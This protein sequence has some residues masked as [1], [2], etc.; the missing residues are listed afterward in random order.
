MSDATPSFSVLLVDLSGSRKKDDQL[1]SYLEEKG[2]QVKTV[3]NPKRAEDRIRDGAAQLVFLLLGRRKGN[4]PSAVLERFH[5][6]NADVPTVVVSPRPSLDQVLTAMRGRAFDFLSS[7]CRWEDI[8]DCVQT[9]IKEKGYSLTLEDRLNTSLGERLRQARNER[10]LTLRQLSSRTGLSVSLISQIELARSS[11]S[12]ATLFKLSRA[13]K[14]RLS[15]LF[16]GF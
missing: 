7:P 10:D 13:L 1:L 4:N 16:S 15:E 12:V 14:I 9:A 8:E 2:F 5:R 11:P 6:A 3:R